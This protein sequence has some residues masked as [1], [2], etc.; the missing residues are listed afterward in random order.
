ML[1]KAPPSN[2]VNI[3]KMSFLTGSFEPKLNL[4]RIGVAFKFHGA[5]D[6]ETADMLRYQ[7]VQLSTE[8]MPA[9]ARLARSRRKVGFVRLTLADRHELRDAFGAALTN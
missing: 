6:P 1:H 4:W 8:D 2:V 9:L 5:L 7:I 3:L